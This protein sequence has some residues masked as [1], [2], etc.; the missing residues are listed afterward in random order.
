MKAVV[1][2]Q[3]H[4]QTGQNQ[5]GMEDLFFD[6]VRHF[7]SDTI[8][9]LH[10]RR[11]NSDIDALL[12]MLTRQRIHEVVLIGYSW[13]AGYAC[14]RFARMA[15]EWGID[16]PLAL[17]CDPVFR[18][19]WMPRWMP[20]NPFNFRSV[21]KSTRITVPRTV[22]RVAWVRQ[23]VSLP[24]GHMLEKEAQLCQFIEPPLVLPYSHTD[25]DEA[26]EWFALVRRELERWADPPKARVV[27]D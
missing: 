25:I 21:T 26:P 11:W 16:I 3:G 10:P 4:L 5:S 27:E 14:M 12:D 19:L 22:R 1:S 23:E 2:F 17:L 20:A 13:G 8:T 9:T 24:A 18:P 15:P 7:A 6:V